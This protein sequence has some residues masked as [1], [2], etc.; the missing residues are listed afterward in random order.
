MSPRGWL[1]ALTDTVAHARTELTWSGLVARAIKFVDP[2]SIAVGHTAEEVLVDVLFIF[3]SN[4]QGVSFD[5]PAAKPSGVRFSDN[6]KEPS[7]RRL[8]AAQE[9]VRTMRSASAARTVTVALSHSCFHQASSNERRF[10]IAHIWSV[11]VNCP[12]CYVV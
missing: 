10:E 4:G 2:I 3:M 9:L 11:V 1:G 5:Q 6:G 12:S 8:D 7:R